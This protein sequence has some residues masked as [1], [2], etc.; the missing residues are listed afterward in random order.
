MFQR[1]RR[2]K[3]DPAWITLPLLCLL[4]VWPFLSRAGLPQET[5][6]ELHIFRLAEMARLVAAGEVFP[7][8]APHFYFGYGYPIFNYYAPLTYLL[9]LLP[10][11]L[12]LGAVGSVKLLFVGGLLLG[13]CATYG[14]V[15]DRWGGRAGLIAAAAF[16]YAP[17]VH[18]VDPH[19]R[20]DLAE[21]FSL[22]LI[23]LSFWM[24]DRLTRQAT[25]GRWLAAAL[26]VSA[27]V[28]THNLMAMVTVA[29]LLA[30]LLWLNLVE[31]AGSRPPAT[32]RR[33]AFLALLVGVGM[34]AFFW[35]PVALEQGAV[36]LSN[37]IGD[38]S[39][40]DFRNHFLE[41]GTLLAPSAWL[42]W[43]AT[44]PDFTLNFGVTQWLLALA[45][46]V[47]LSFDARRSR[48]GI[49]FVVAGLLLLA[50]MLPLSAPV[51]D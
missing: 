21:A 36:N 11:A 37:L 44:E 10:M 48:A 17:Y 7:R 35:L 2:F 15:R 9:G 4:A 8:W 41:L 12:G 50:L 19:A 34:A 13:A 5:D 51:W 24:L 18:F 28:T 23:P 14:F 39:H 16:V 40:F 49:F 30:W 22:A 1:F 20:G 31:P 45:G 6:A 42:D 46:A 43:R 47:M 33:L 38:G 26:A 25:S 27:V 3:A 32:G 29:M